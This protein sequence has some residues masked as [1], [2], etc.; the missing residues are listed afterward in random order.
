M[1]AL[2]GNQ[3]FQPDF[4][5]TILPG[6]IFFV[7]FCL[8]VMI[9]SMIR[10]EASS[11]IRFVLVSKVLSPGSTISPTN[12]FPKPNTRIFPGTGTFFSLRWRMICT[13]LLSDMEIMASMPG[14]NFS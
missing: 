4:L 12:S 13:A 10:L 3:L 6:M 8:P 5:K 11:P 9:C 2:N 7:K 1:G 14:F